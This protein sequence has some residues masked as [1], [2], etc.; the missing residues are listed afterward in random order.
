MKVFAL[1][2]VVV[3]GPAGRRGGAGPRRRAGGR[4]GPAGRGR[5][6]G[7]PGRR[8][9]GGGPAAGAAV[10]GRPVQA[11]GG[12]GRVAAAEGADEAEVDLGSRRQPAVPG[13]TA[14]GD[15]GPGL[16]PVRGP[17]L[18]HLLAG[19]RPAVRQA[20]AAQRVTGIGDGDR[21]LETAGP[22]ARHRVAH[23]TTGGRRG[24]HRHV[25]ESPGRHREGRRRDGRQAKDGAHALLLVERFSGRGLQA[26]TALEVAPPVTQH[27]LVEIGDDGRAA[28]LHDE[29]LARGRIPVVEI[30]QPVA[31]ADLVQTR[32]GCCRDSSSPRR[33]STRCRSAGPSHRRRHH[34]NPGRQPQR[35]VVV[36]RG[37][38]GAAGV[39]AVLVEEPPAGLRTLGAF[40]WMLFT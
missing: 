36:A 11:E 26:V 21:S 37:A 5:A 27:P 4:R 29:S 28:R 22:L 31:V 16:R 3:G 40:S 7:R 24:G 13:R 32:Y 33:R 12:R 30:V 10:A 35:H 14:G 23:G 8:G 25:H 34:S 1:P 18:A 2:V 38:A 15:L 39:V 17:A 9:R 19:V 20:P 6:G